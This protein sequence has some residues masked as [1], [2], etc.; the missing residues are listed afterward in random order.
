MVIDGEISASTT[1]EDIFWIVRVII[2]TPPR[3]PDPPRVLTATD[4]PEPRVRA[5]PTEPRRDPRYDER[6]P[7]HYPDGFGYD[8]SKI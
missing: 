3:M 5:E 2:P 7:I 8:D 6:L 1:I 4:I